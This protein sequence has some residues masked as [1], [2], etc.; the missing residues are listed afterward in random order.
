MKL[1]ASASPVVIT[2]RHSVPSYFLSLLTLRVP[3]LSPQLAGTFTGAFVAVTALVGYIGGIAPVQRKNFLLAFAWL[4]VIAMLAELSLGGVIWFK[5]LTMR[6]LFSHQWP[7]WP[8]SLKVAFQDMV[9][10]GHRCIGDRQT[11]QREVILTLISFNISW[12]PSLIDKSFRIWSM[13]RI[14]PW[15]ECGFVRCLY[16]VSFH[17]PR[18]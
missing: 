5:T 16:G 1:E 4:M 18:M 14:W 3:F 17:I 2:A 13:L 8:D 7:T 11:L 10:P 9:R 15:R 12:L 6:S